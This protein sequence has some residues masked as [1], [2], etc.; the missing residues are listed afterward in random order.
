MALAWPLFPDEYFDVSQSDFGPV[1]F[2]PLSEFAGQATV[3][4]RLGVACDN[5]GDNG[6]A[7]RM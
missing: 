5:G 7:L 1:S 3:R 2:E 4:L 6:A